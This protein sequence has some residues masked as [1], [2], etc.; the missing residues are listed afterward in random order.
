MMADEEPTT[1]DAAAAEEVDVEQS[2]PEVEAEVET[3]AESTEAAPAGDPAVVPEAE[4]AAEPVA[5]PEAEAEVGGEESAPE[6]A[7]AESE[8]DA[9]ESEAEGEA[10][11]AASEADA[12]PAAESDADA[13]VGED[14]GEAAPA[15]AAAPPKPAP[16]EV[17]APK[18]R[19]RLKRAAKAPA[20]RDEVTPEDRQVERDA[21]RAHKAKARRTGRAKTRAAKPAA[22]GAAPLAVEHAVGRPKARQGI[23][24]S[25]K[26]A[27]TIT[28]RVDTSRRHRRYKKIVRS[29]KTLHAHD[30]HDEAHEGDLVRVVETRP[31]SA[32]KR[33]RL[34]EVLERAK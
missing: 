25:D 18:E 31:L 8:A 20:T 2:A 32:T 9:A 10:P 14:D 19:R 11:E 28:V 34:L 17:I 29:S 24:V 5:E 3:Q 26:A 1:A 15:A 12:A 33:W 7:A 16:A 22:E 27:K 6:T 4:A 23:V 13:E 30:E 21:L